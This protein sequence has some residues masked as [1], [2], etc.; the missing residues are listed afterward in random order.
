MARNTWRVALLLPSVAGSS[1]VRALSFLHAHASHVGLLH[2]CLEHLG[3]LE[4]QFCTAGEEV[5]SFMRPAPIPNDDETSM[6]E[7]SV[8]ADPLSNE[9][10]A[11]WFETARR[12]REI[13]TEVF[14]PVPSNL[15]RNWDAYDVRGSC[16]QLRD[17]L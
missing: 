4:P 1:A 6:R 16:F 11:L 12:N 9:M 5:T 3:L 15:V 14:R 2:G 17:V 13:F 7:D 8:V 10:E